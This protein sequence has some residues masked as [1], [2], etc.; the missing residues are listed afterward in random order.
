MKGRKTQTD[1]DAG[2]KAIAEREKTV[3]DHNRAVGDLFTKLDEAS[4]D[5]TAQSNREGDE[6]RRQERESKANPWTD[7]FLPFAA[8]AAA[9]GVYGELANRGLDRF[10]RGNAQALREIADELGPTNKLTTSQLNR[11]RAAG[12]AAA[13]ERF[14]P[15]NPLLK[16]MNTVGRAASYGIPAAVLYNEYSNYQGRANDPNLTESE[17]GANQQIANALLG[18]TTGIGVE[19]GRRFFFPSREPGLGAAQMR[20][21]T[22]RDLATRLDAKDAAA[23]A[24]PPSTPTKAAEAT[25]APSGPRA[26]TPGSRADLMKQAKRYN[27]AGRSTM[28]V[29]QLREAVGEAVKSTPAPRG[30]AAT[31]MLKGLAGP[32]A[33]ASLAYAM[34][35]DRAEAGG[36][37]DVSRYISSRLVSSGNNLSRVADVYDDYTKFAAARGETP[38]P[39]AA[40]SRQMREGG[41][42]MGRMANENQY[43]AS[44]RPGE[45]QAPAR[46]GGPAEALT[47]AGIAGG[48]AYGVGR[49]IDRLPAA[50]G[51]AMRTAGEAFAPS[52]I[53][54]MTDY[55]PDELAQ[56]RNWMARNL[57]EAL[58][59]GAVGEAR[60]MATVPSPSPYRQQPLAAAESLEAPEMDFDTQLADLTSLLQQIGAAPNPMQTAQASRAVTQL[61]QGF[62][63]SNVPTNRLLAQY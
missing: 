41:I 50:V 17:R 26:V 57:P 23:S 14:A 11:S 62:A 47:N 13:A 28:S 24:P 53:D 22:A 16:G 4:K 15:T 37:A 8:G 31:K 27:I 29:E 54:A 7:T 49:A 5:E 45:Y 34:T 35:P 25:P 58:Q 48:A 32:A 60:E 18:T 12:A 20:I 39:L 1:I 30:G 46:G 44:I 56:G 9:G 43:M 3:A 6:A 19:G 10:E 52:T 59:F 21:Q 2:R 42:G 51:G 61:P 33:A 38:I 55:S 40:F 36:P 63:P